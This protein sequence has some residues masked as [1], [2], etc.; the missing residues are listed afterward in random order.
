LFALFGC[1]QSP[2][3]LLAAEITGQV[4]RPPAKLQ[5]PKRIARYRTN[6]PTPA[7]QPKGDCQCNPGLF[8]VISLTSDIVTEVLPL[9][10][11]LEMNQQTT[12]FDPSVLAVTVNS[13]VSFPNLDL[14]YHN[15]FSYS[16]AKKF[17]LGKYPR[18][19]TKYVTLNKSGIVQVFCEIHYSMRAY[20]HVM[21]TP[22]FA[23][24]DEQ[25]RFIIHDVPAGTYCVKVWQEGQS[26]ITRD[27]VISSDS[28]WIDLR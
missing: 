14:Y 23:V 16:K 4:T 21:E 20:V 5:Q 27:L 19:E 1:I 22:Y 7:E 9:K 18:G 15:V 10:D 26:P 11:T 25:G 6:T 12:T 2:E 28:V 8:S 13:T 3:R 24:S 17:D